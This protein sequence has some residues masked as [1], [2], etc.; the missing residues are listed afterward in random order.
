MSVE[1]YQRIT[2][3]VIIESANLVSVLLQESEGIVVSKVFKLDQN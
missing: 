2:L 3:Y 1:L